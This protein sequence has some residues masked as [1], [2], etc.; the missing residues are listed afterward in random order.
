MLGNNIKGISNR[1]CTK[2]EQFVDVD[3]VYFGPEKRHLV[4][5]VI[6]KANQRP[7]YTTFVSCPAGGQKNGQ[8][9]TDNLFL[10]FIGLFFSV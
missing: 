1:I 9:K 2:T 5:V 8:S 7:L 4:V 10:V 6:A 3:G